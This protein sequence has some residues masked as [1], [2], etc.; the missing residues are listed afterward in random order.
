MLPALE[1]KQIKTSRIAWMVAAVFFVLML[2]PFAEGNIFSQ[3]WAVAFLSFFFGISSVIVAVMYQMRSNKFKKLISGEMAIAQWTLTELDKL[4]FIDRQYE[5]RKKKNKINFVL[6]SVLTVV[7][8]GFFII[9]MDDDNRMV[10]VYI[11]LGFLLLFGF[12]A[13]YMPGHFRNK[14]LKGDA[15]IIIGKKFA[16]IN[17][18]FHNWDFPFSGIEN[19]EIIEEPFHGIHLVYYYYAKSTVRNTEEIDIP[20]PKNID[21]NDLKEKLLAV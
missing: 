3:L 12:F 6:V 11:M 13:F 18:F 2:L 15:H 20:A 4:K 16:Y 8:F 10:M 7:I 17:G 19:I 1:N 5:E 21:L 9:M 14:N